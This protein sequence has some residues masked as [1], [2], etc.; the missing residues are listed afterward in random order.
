MFG[1]NLKTAPQAEK[2]CMSLGHA[3][4]TLHHFTSGFT[5]GGTSLRVLLPQQTGPPKELIFRA[6]RAKRQQTGIHVTASRDQKSTHARDSLRLGGLL[7]TKG[8]T[9][10]MEIF[11][12]E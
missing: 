4:E 10:K 1:E 8:L 9:Q 11:C 12:P 3:V 2:A 6:F 7:T 5:P